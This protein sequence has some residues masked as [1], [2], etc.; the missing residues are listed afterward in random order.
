MKHYW[1]SK[2]RL[3]TMLVVLY[4]FV[5]CATME[6]PTGGAADTVPPELVVF[7]PD[8]AAVNVPVDSQL[9]YLFSEKVKPVA[10]DRMFEFYPELDIKSGSW[11]KRQQ[12]KI[13]LETPLPPDTTIVVTLAKGYMDVHGFA[14]DKTVV[15]PFATGAAIDSCSITGRLTMNNGP[16]ISGLLELYSIPPDSIEYFQQDPLRRASTDSLGYYNFQ[17]LPTDGGPYLIRAFSDN[18]GDRRPG[19]NEATRL[20]PDE[21]SQT[22]QFVDNG[23]TVIFAPSTPGT[24]STIVNLPLPENQ[25]V[26]SWTEKIGENDDPWTPDDVTFPSN[27]QSVALNDTLVFNE[28]GPGDVRVFFFADVN[29]DTLFSILPDSISTDSVQYYFEPHLTIENIFIEP[30][31]PETFI[32]TAWPDTLVPAIPDSLK[33]E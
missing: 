12:V 9:I 7:F 11:S 27:A 1:H 21:I 19:D 30:G 23:E 32:M 20:F 16:V 3:A 22:M 13:N 14:A 24:L 31:M 29:S 28:A 15:Y 18:N 6:A 4:L 25:V 33:Q 26:F 10:P 5:G 2:T 17:W 8:S